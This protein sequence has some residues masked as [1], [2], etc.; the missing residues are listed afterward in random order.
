MSTIF[1]YNDSIIGIRSNIQRCVYDYNN[2]ILVLVKDIIS[3]NNLSI[4]VILDGDI[5][6]IDINNNKTIKLAINYE[7]TLVKE[8]GRSVAKN[9]PMGNIKTDEN[10]N[11]LVRIDR[12]SQLNS[13]NI[14]IDYSNPNIFNVKE[15]G[16]YSD[17]SNKHIYIAPTLYENLY[18]EIE[19]RNI[20]SLTTFINTNEPRRKELLEKISESTL[21]HRN[22][23]NC[24]EKSKIKELYQNTKVVINIHQ[25][26]HHHT[27]EELRCLPA[28]QN[29]VIVISEKSPLNN[30]IPY[31]ELII[32]SDY[33]NII[34]KTKEVL[35]NYEEFH[36]KIFKEEN[37]KIL[38]KMNDENK[39]ELEKK[40]MNYISEE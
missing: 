16:V 5:T 40:I 2:Y 32:W 10:N 34:D 8:G 29:G 26:P 17:F 4:N 28:L 11:Y 9:T 36:K 18:I 24:F 19:N 20:D 27:F 15:C 35:E 30:L 33:N 3:K 14:I 37:I 31:N 23:N 25:T 13:S 1:K 7:H 12:Y 21:N 22:V 38:K 6:L 39:I